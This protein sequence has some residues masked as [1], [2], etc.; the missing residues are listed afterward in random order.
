VINGAAGRQRIEDILQE[1]PKIKDVSDAIEL[2]NFEREIYFDNVSFKYSEDRCG[3]ENLSLKIRKGD[4]VAFVGGSG[5]GKSTIVNLITRLYEPTSGKI[6]FD[7]IDLCQATMGSLRSQIGL[8]SQE[9][10]LFNYSMRENIR[11][12][13]LKATDEAV[14]TAAKAAQIHDFILTLPE[15]YDSSVGDRGG[16]L[17]GGQKQRIAL[18]RAL[19]RN[20]AILILDEAT[21]ALDPLTEAEIISTLEQLA[22]ERTVIVITHSLKQVLGANTIFVLEN[23]KLVASGSHGNLIEQEGL[24]ASLWQAVSTPTQ[25]NPV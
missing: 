13:N 6:L 1:V 9:V 18:A 7:G 12:G 2:S 17:S 5:A 24:Y 20:P 10:I 16:Q 19:I 23:G 15:G 8:V 4:F 22:K 25:L 21:S 3:I 14:E 11:M